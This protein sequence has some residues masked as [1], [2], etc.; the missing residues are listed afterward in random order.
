[1]KF[2][3]IIFC[4]LVWQPLPLSAGEILVKNCAD[5]FDYYRFEIGGAIPSV[6]D[7]NFIVDFILEK[8]GC[9]PF[10]Y[11]NE[12]HV[13]CPWSEVHGF[14]SPCLKYNQLKYK[15]CQLKE[16]KTIVNMDKITARKTREIADELC[17]HKALD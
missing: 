1:M 12:E 4:I 15:K 6:N 17:Y 16:Y 13:N 9:M 3:L 7:V 11:I 14:Y 2:K 10:D 8:D 5:E